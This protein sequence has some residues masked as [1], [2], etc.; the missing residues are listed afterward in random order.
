M[1]R[2][3]QPGLFSVLGI[4]LYVLAWSGQLAAGAHSGVPHI[5]CA[6]HGELSHIAIARA[7]AGPLPLERAAASAQDDS[8][9]GGHEHCPIAAVVDQSA[10]PARSSPSAV[11]TLEQSQPARPIPRDA[12]PTDP[13]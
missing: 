10:R 8:H 9:A 4:I 5:R 13:A 6:E 3:S 12:T 11:T 1:R 7:E 2:R